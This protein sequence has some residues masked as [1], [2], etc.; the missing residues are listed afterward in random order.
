MGFLLQMQKQLK[1]FPAKSGENILCHMYSLY[2]SNTLG[3]LYM[4]FSH[5]CKVV[6]NSLLFRS[7]QNSNL[8]LYQVCSCVSWLSAISLNL[9]SVRHR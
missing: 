5:T 2:C 3:L 7:L 9:L 1:K 4:F 6:N 8:H